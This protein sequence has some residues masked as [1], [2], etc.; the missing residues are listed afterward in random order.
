MSVRGEHEN[1]MAWRKMYETLDDSLRDLDQMLPWFRLERVL[2]FSIYNNIRGLKK[3]WVELRLCDFYRVGMEPDGLDEKT[4]T[5]LQAE[6]A[7]VT[8][9]VNQL[10]ELVAAAT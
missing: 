3:R 10:K 7:R 1:E 6:E 2:L 8:S 5:M 4:R 9:L